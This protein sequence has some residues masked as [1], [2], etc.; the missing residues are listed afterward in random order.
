M[1]RL[2]TPEDLLAMRIPE[3]PQLSADGSLIA[4]MLTEIDAGEF[5][6]RR[7][8]WV[9]PAAGGEPRRFTVGPKDGSPR[10]SP[11]GKTL[12]FVRAP[13][14]STKPANAEERARGVG[15]PQIWLIPAD[16]G[17]AR[18]LTYQRHG[19]TSP[20]WS[21]DGSTLL[22]V[23]ETGDLD[24]PEVDDAALNGKNLPRVRGITHLSYRFEGHGFTYELRAHLFT[25]PASGGEPRQLTDGDWND[26]APSWSPDGSHI[27]FVSDRSDERWR[28]A[29][30]A[31]WTLALDDLATTRLTDESLACLAP[32]WAPDSA[33]IAFLAAPVRGGSGHDDLYVVAADPAQ[34]PAVRLSE[35]FIP[36]CQDR[37][38]DDVR[39]D[40]LPAQLTWTPDG[41]GIYFLASLRGATHLYL[42][43]T[44]ENAIPQ[45]IAGGDRRIY[46]YSLDTARQSLAF[47]AS[48]PTMPGD[49]FA[50]SLA[51]DEHDERRLTHLNA[52]L[53]DDIT[54]AQ[55]EE[56]AF[57]GADGWELQGWVMRPPQ[58]TPGERVPA[59]L[60]I[61]GGPAFMYG[62]SFFTEFQ[63]LAAQG[64]AVVYSNPRG[65][66]GYGRHFMHAV[67][68][69]WGGKDYE[70]VMA[71]LDAAL[72][73]GDLD[74]DRL[75][76]AGGSYGGYMTNW[77]VGHT[78]RFKAAVTMRSVVNIANFFG[79]S[80]TGWWLAVDEIGATPWE[81][82]NK[83]MFHSPIT[84]V[85]NVHTPLLILH[86]DGDL[87]C[88]IADAEALFASLAYLG[89]TTRF[90]RFEGQNHNLSRTG[91]P[92]SRLIRLR[93]ILSW[94]AQ[95]N[96]VSVAD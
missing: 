87:R 72:Q 85:A 8:L 56:F 96:P 17:E 27:A 3:E 57:T 51:S 19:A 68:H 5:A 26:G 65:S 23:A 44:E 29:G 22:F 40:H 91:H 55:P 13:H 67:L 42:A 15:K 81:D 78:D 84:Y 16:G 47:V 12:A 46:G 88:P 77:I 76:V 52:A 82:L 53:L 31:L 59:I 41:K 32:E 10:W 64:Y 36:V 14:E 48:D 62:Y 28:W 30:G 9:A 63:L 34:G 93:E 20:V 75:G 49:L 1:P 90:V 43:R 45:V 71:G 58:S 18:Q 79:T 66:A 33:Q 4:F 50:C 60:E 70:D 6:Y 73:R 83:L 24:D 92:R 7:S 69:D 89:R 37:C 21:P 39:S 2:L 61:H 94:F 25:V 86:S 80:D 74:P 95:Y 38:L 54:L 11:D 35:D